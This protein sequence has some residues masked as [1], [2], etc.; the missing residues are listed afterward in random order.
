MAWWWG[1][2]P[3]LLSGRVPV[4]IDFVPQKDLLADGRERVLLTGLRGPVDNSRYDPPA[5][6]R[7]D[8][9]AYES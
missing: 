9:R 6:C 8:H 1:F 3:K 7:T 5:S 4:S 2:G